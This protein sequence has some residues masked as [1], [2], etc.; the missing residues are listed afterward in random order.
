ME[1]L[2]IK[3]MSVQEQKIYEG[4]KKL[5]D[6]IKQNPNHETIGNELIENL[7]S[8]IEAWDEKFNIEFI[9]KY[10][11]N[12]NLYTIA[13]DGLADVFFPGIDETYVEFMNSKATTELLKNLFKLRKSNSELL[14]SSNTQKF[15]KMSTVLKRNSIMTHLKNTDLKARPIQYTGRFYVMMFS[16]LSTTI[17]KYDDLRKTLMYLKDDVVSV[18]TDFENLQWQIRFIVDKFLIKYDLY[19]SCSKWFRSA[20]AWF[21]LN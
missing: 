1:N 21:I 4:Y 8:D 7:H 20:I 15:I 18:D 9:N 16:E 11:I 2:N 3:D 19:G 5:K 14:N 17:A 12:E 10:L 6:F 13:A